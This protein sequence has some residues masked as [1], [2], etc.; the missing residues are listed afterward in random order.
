MKNIYLIIISLTILSC[1][2][3]LEMEAPSPTQYTLTV[4]AGLGG[5]VSQGGAYD[6][7]TEV[8]I[9]ATAADGYEFIGWSGSDSTEA[10][11]TT[12]LNSNTTFEAIFEFIEV[13]F[14][15][16]NAT[17]D[18]SEQ[19]P[20]RAK[21]TIYG[22]W[23]FGNSSETSKS[24]EKDNHPIKSIFNKR[25]NRKKYKSK[26]LSQKLTCSFNFIEFLDDSYIMAIE[27]DGYSE[28]LSGDFIINENSEGKVSTVDLKY[29]LGSELITIATLSDIIVVETDS[30]LDA[31]F[32]ILLNIP[33]DADFVSCNSLSGNF[34]VDK[35]EPMGASETA[36]E[37]SNHAMLI[38]TWEFISIID[39]DYPDDNEVA[40][41]K[42][43]YCFDYGGVYDEATDTYPLIENC[44]PPTSISLTFSTYGTYTVMYEGGS[45]GTIVEVDTWQWIDDSQTKL[46]IGDDSEYEYEEYTSPPIIIET[47]TDDSLIM[48]TFYEAYIDT[49][50]PEYSQPA[51]TVTYILSSQ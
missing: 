40:L 43:E 13:D 41:I 30:K 33:A 45:D 25:D 38:N 50:Y 36:I 5:T 15:N 17:G 19:S 46:S 6:E 27:S 44:S 48:S 16:L 29:N 47:L 9:T 24:I 32:E 11:L 7:G 12:T 35:E 18:L 4:S 34:S 31:T 3:E 28:Y 22:K 10:S 23:N 42:E 20:E 51:Y 39:S 49:E 8:T 2:D 21:K 14:T 1:S 26:G 37:G